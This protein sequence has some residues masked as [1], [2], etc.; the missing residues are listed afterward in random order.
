MVGSGVP[1][2]AI[3]QFIKSKEEEIYWVG[4]SSDKKFADRDINPRL[5]F[6]QDIGTYKA[7]GNSGACLVSLK[8]R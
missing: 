5:G 1:M 6:Y 4:H 7:T 3:S 8:K 2:S